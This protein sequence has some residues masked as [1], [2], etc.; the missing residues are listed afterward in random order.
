MTTTVTDH[1]VVICG[2]LWA[3]GPGLVIEW[4]RGAAHIQSTLTPD[5]I[6]RMD[7]EEA[8]KMIELA[9][10]MGWRVLEVFDAR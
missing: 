5:M 4:S 8:S 10:A 6:Q 1:I 3:E 2:F 9:L 7:R